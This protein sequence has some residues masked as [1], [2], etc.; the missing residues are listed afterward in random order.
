MA[1]ISK[2][3]LPDNSVVNIKDARITGVDSTPTSGS[4]N[5]VE[6]GGIKEAIME[7]AG[8]VII[9]TQTAA[10]GN[11]TG[12]S[13]LATASDMKSGYRFT[14]WLPY[15]GSG[16]ATLTLT[17]Q[18]GTTK[19]I[20]CY[21]NGASRL[22]THIGAGNK[23]D[24]LYLENASVAGT[25][26]TG[27]WIDKG[28]QD[29][30]N[31]DRVLSN[32]ERRFI[33]SAQTPLYRYKICGYNGGKIVPITITDQ[34]SGTIVDKT[35]TNVGLDTTMGLCYYGT[36]P[37]ITT[38]ST[39][40][41]ALYNEGTTTSAHYTFNDTVPAYHDVYLKGSI[42][43]DRLFYLDI[44]TNKSWYVF[45]PNRLSDGEYNSVFKSGSYYMF[46]GPTYSSNNYM[47][48]KYNNP[49]YF[50]NGE[51]LVLLEDAKSGE[52]EES[53]EFL[54]RKSPSLTQGYYSAKEIKG[55]TLVW[56]QLAETKSY[57][58]TDVDTRTQFSLEVLNG[59]GTTFKTLYN[60]FYAFDTPSFSTR[61][62]ATP[63]ING[64]LRLK[65]NGSSR[66]LDF[67]RVNGIISS[68]KY[69]LGFTVL[70]CNTTTVGGFT[71][72]NAMAIDLTLM[73]GAGNEP[74]TV[75]EFE[76]LFPL[77]YYDYNPGELISFNAT[78]IETTGF[79]QWDEEWENG[80]FN[81]TTGIDI[82][83]TTQIR[84]KNK[85]RVSPD[86]LYY[87]KTLARTSTASSNSLWCIFYD[88]N[89]NVIQ[90]PNISGALGSSG[91]S[92]NLSGGFRTPTDA[93]YM[94]FYAQIFYGDT[95]ENDICIN[96][97]DP[98]KNGTYEPYKK[99][100]LTLD[101]P[102]M[103]SNNVQI[104]PDGMRSAGSVCD[105]AVVDS[106][107]Y[108]RKVTKRIGSVLLNGGNDQSYRIQSINEHG[109]ANFTY[110]VEGRATGAITTIICDKLE[111]QTAVI[112]NATEEG[113]LT[114]NGTLIYLRIKET[115]ASTTTE[116][117]TYLA[118]NPVYFAYE[119]ATPVEYT[120]DE[121]IFVGAEYYTGGVQRVIPE[122]TSEPTTAPFRG[123]FG[124]R[125]YSYAEK[126]DK[127]TFDTTPTE[128]SA[129]PVTSGGLYAEL[130]DVVRQG[131]MERLT[132]AEI[133]NLLNL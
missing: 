13:K 85:I 53:T 23:I 104:F 130:A 96:V 28:Y 77:P 50:F 10:T 30:N 60:Q 109:I 124:Y 52:I 19:A 75:E 35:P 115:S 86:T 49:V 100:T 87:I 120:L 8:E 36:S 127:L 90:S 31:Y 12:V 20:N 57:S 88:D 47:Q 81:T 46:V 116:L 121:P 22:T 71:T 91:N 133:T 16:N 103:T 69:L 125:D 32:Y 67:C 56:N 3:K 122:N 63:T 59:D 110:Y 83:L 48:L 123:K 4:A 119:L 1:D 33:Y 74:S 18:D 6:S 105:S 93:A 45:A 15:A 9:G 37:N 128:N 94:R 39:T 41:T 68:H 44:A 38:I 26:Y 2:I 51:R 95:Y 131:D 80:T 108:I 99:S 40:V 111:R 11:W 65:H 129:N 101:V 73:F 92:R 25:N 34:T 126:Q 89:N 70:T 97:F 29:G 118:S 54:C 7:S 79:N 113:F 102:S 14:Y 78:G 107:G 21:W 66:D 98:S 72:D 76:S 58:N 42:G 5:V 62:I 61:L 43:S 84:A 27:A 114:S 24:F 112:A 17:F 106:D 82:T 64:Y 117:K 55:R 132:T